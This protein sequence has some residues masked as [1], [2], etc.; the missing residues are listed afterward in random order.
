[1]HKAVPR[2]VSSVVRCSAGVVL[3][4]QTRVLVA[5]TPGAGALGATVVCPIASVREASL[6]GR[7]VV[8]MGDLT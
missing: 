2:F 3:P 7:L 8:V 4:V 6:T 5:N 1:M